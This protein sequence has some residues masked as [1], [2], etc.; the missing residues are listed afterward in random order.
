MAMRSSTS[1]N[2]FD[3]CNAVLLTVLG[4]SMIYPF[5]FSLCMSF[6]DAAGANAGGFFLWPRGFSTGAY[7]RIFAD[8]MLVSGY[9]NTIFR[10]AV[11]VP[12]T[13][14]ACSLCAYPLSRRCMP[15]RK[16]AMFFVL[17]TM[18]FGGGLVPNYLLFNTLGLIDNR[19]V[20]I[21]PTLIGAFNVI[22]IR[23]YF[24]S[25]SE[26]LYE[27]AAMDG[28]SDWYIFTRIYLP[29]SKPI[30]AT[31]AMF[32]AISHWNAWFDSMLY[33]T[34]ESKMVVQTFLQRIV[35]EG[36]VN[37]GDPSLIAQN[38]TEFTPETVKAAT[39]VIT[40]LPM[41]I[42]YPFVQKFFTKGIMLGGV[43][44]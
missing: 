22:L 18:M 13:V 15:H 19:A 11:G 17:F 33:M 42:L 24:Q 31:V 1:G 43:K 26:S 27:A 3:A 38:L 21:I 25:I 41:M 14:F 29:L 30:L 34:S 7:E 32:S 16:K 6:S 10:T 36:N 44:E 28:A 5:W 12:A 9:L 40:V 35:I 20:Y 37:I 23:N 39:V 8:D 4:L 2:V